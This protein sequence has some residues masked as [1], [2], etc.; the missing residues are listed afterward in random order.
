MLPDAIRRAAA[1]IDEAPTEVF[2]AAHSN[3]FKIFLANLL[4]VD[5]AGT[6]PSS[7]RVAF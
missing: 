3:V 1:E 4:L 6:V 7:R 5:V 2:F